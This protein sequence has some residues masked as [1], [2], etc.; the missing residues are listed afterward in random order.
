MKNVR[1]KPHI[2]AHTAITTTTTK[3]PNSQKFNNM[4]PYDRQIYI[5]LLVSFIYC[6][7]FYRGGTVAASYSSFVVACLLAHK[8]TK[9]ACLFCFSTSV[10]FLF[11]LLIS[12]SY[13]PSLFYIIEFIF[14]P[15]VV[16][17]SSSSLFFSFSF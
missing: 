8:T 7:F 4:T 5:L 10:F 1:R 11:S 12:Y 16:F 17:L 6:L 14:M 13:F 3:I 15:F 2:R 9:Y